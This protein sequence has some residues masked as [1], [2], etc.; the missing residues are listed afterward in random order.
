M[1][2]YCTGGLGGKCCF[3]ADGSSLPAYKRPGSN[4]CLFCTPGVVRENLNVQQIGH[5]RRALG[6]FSIEVHAKAIAKFPWL[7]SDSITVASRERAIAAPTLRGAPT[8]ICGLWWARRPRLQ[9]TRCVWGSAVK[10]GAFLISQIWAR[11]R[12]RDQRSQLVFGA[13]SLGRSKQQGRSRKLEGKCC[14]R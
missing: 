14:K 8:A 3:R 9:H 5:L 12:L 10:A 7:S 6:H 13:R 4:L 1:S 11:Q 2:K